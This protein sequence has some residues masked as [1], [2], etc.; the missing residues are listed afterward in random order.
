MARLQNAPGSAILRESIAGDPPFEAVHGPP[1]HFSAT[2]RNAWLADDFIQTLDDLIKFFWRHP[3]NSLA[4]P[5]L[6]AS[7]QL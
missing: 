1:N 5:F 2:G 6:S 4:D 7:R 3:G